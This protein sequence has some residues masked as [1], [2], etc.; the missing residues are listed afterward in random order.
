M[1]TFQRSNLDRRSGD[2]RRAVYDLDY[3]AGDGEERRDTQMKR[4][5]HRERRSGWVRI[6]P[7]ASVFVGA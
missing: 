6:G 7:W 1:G 4:R 3:F 2:D 5:S